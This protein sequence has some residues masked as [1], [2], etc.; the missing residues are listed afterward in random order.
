MQH[1]R[2]KRKSHLILGASALEGKESNIYTYIIV[3]CVA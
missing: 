3:C 2:K 1:F